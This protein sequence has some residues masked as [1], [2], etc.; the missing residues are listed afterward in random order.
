M[1]NLTDLRKYIETKI[2]VTTGVLKIFT[3]SVEDDLLIKPRTFLEGIEPRLLNCSDISTLK[4]KILDIER[5]IQSYN[6]KIPQELYEIFISFINTLKEKVHI[7]EETREATAEGKV[8]PIR[9]SP[10]PK[11]R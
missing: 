10:E 9:K 7:K 4:Q 11:F 1:E 2:K 8:V 3:L 6:G 5:E